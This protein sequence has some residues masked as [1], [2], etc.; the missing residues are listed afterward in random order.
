M[1]TDNEDNVEPEEPEID[2][3]PEPS[4]IPPGTF[5]GFGEPEP[6]QPLD[7]IV[8][9]ECF[10]KNVIEDVHI[11]ECSTCGEHYCMHFASVVDPAH[12]IQCVNEVV[13]DESIIHKTEIPHNPASAPRVR[14]ARQIKIG[15]LHWLFVQRKI[16]DI[17]D[18]SLALAIEYH[19]ALFSALNYERDKR[20]VESFHRNAGKSFKVPTATV[21][22]TDTTEIKRT[23]NKRTTVPKPDNAQAQMI[24]ALQA[25]TA[26]GMTPAQ[27]KSLLAKK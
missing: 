10:E 23:R 8:C 19:Y 7:N 26:S 24:A 22:I 17:D 14:K 4:E 9:D 27:I 21:K 3:A 18:A 16:K 2:N 1:A 11:Q 12:C 25:L 13:M 6:I 20:R 15:G 5:D